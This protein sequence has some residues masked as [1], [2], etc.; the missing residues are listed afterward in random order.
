M[1]GKKFGRLT[2]TEF[3]GMYE[4]PSGQKRKSYLCQCECGNEK[5]VLVSGLRSKQTQSCGCLHKEI[6]SGRMIDLTGKR[7]GKL[8]VTGERKKIGINYHWLC[9][10]DCGNYKYTNGASLRHGRSKSCG[11]GQGGVIHGLSSQPGP[12]NKYLR[13]DPVKK[14]RHNIGVAVRDALK[15]NGGSKRGYSIFD[16]LPYTFVEL[17]SHLESQFDSWMSWNNYGG[18]NDNPERT[19]H[20]DHVIPQANFNFKSMDDPQF[21]ECWSLENLQPL[22]KKANMSKGAR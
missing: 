18:R 21:L 4:F 15:V 10:C 1:I 13:K 6:M 22:E 3:A 20:V 2:I 16:Y 17:K 19:W 7:F 8:V 5:I 9:K 11:C 12:Y 14:L